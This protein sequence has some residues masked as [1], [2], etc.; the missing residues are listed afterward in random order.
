[1]KRILPTESWALIFAFALMPFA[2]CFWDIEGDIYQYSDVKWFLIFVLSL[3]LLVSSFFSRAEFQVPD[4]SQVPWVRRALALA[5]VG[6]AVSC[7]LGF[8]GRFE[9]HLLWGL[10]FFILWIFAHSWSVTGEAFALLSGRI[11][12]ANAVG[13][14]G[15]AGY[16]LVQKAGLFLPNLVVA[17]GQLV[18]F[19]GNKNY[20]ASYYSFALLIHLF[21]FPRS[22]SR[23]YGWAYWLVTALGLYGL[24]SMRARGASLGFLAGIGVF[25]WHRV[26][27]SRFRKTGVALAMAA[28]IGVAVVIGSYRNVSPESDTRMIRIARWANTLSMIRE[29][30]LGVGPGRF[31]W[32]YYQYA[33]KVRNDWE[34]TEDV[35]TKSPHNI[36]LEIAAENGLLTLLALL[37]V[38]AVALARSGRLRPG[39][40][41]W[42][43]AFLVDGFFSF[44]LRVPDNFFVAG[45]FCGFLTSGA[46][47]SRPFLTGRLSKQVRGLL[48][49][50]FGFIGVLQF[51][52]I[53]NVSIS[54]KDTRRLEAACLQAPWWVE[55]C[56][57]LCVL[58]ANEGRLEEAEQTCREVLDRQPHMVKIMPVLAGIVRERG[59]SREYCRIMKQFDG[60]FEGKSS[61]HPDLL[62]ACQ[63]AP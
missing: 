6:V 32:D 5:G 48:A 55:A 54:L 36:F 17:P 2:V 19:F 26:G 35:V 31:D 45:V 50:L 51:S 27:W 13:L 46:F 63:A 61:A 9:S 49:I 16:L 15:V 18:S 21:Y 28:L 52:A 59:N 41:A 7:F 14:V 56:S 47:P 34:V 12:R 33:R 62:K 53:W 24:F 4:L 11:A 38:L 39:V 20:A 25:L 23:K 8:P 60:Y 44:P 1:M 40:A 43:V 58:E 10:G 22:A 3:F 57:I 29:H 42:I 37:L 30:P